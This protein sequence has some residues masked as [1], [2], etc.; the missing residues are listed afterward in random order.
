ME[1]TEF[2]EAYRTYET[3]L[4]NRGIEYRQVEEASDEET[5]NR[6]RIIRQIRNYV[7]HTNDPGF[8]TVT[9]VMMKWLNHK[10]L[11]ERLKLDLVKDHLWTMRQG[12]LKENESLKTALDRMLKR[13]ET[14]LPVMDETGKILLGAASF[15]HLVKI[16]LKHPEGM[17]TKKEYGVWEPA[18]E[19]PWDTAASD[20]NVQISLICMENGKPIGVVKRS[21]WPVEL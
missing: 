7:T 13:E 1:L 10:I 6:M 11:E 18:G 20:V 17:L 4:R 19:I 8:L 5:M 16:F 21:D 15:D 2:L 12:A 9:P 14:E 3:L